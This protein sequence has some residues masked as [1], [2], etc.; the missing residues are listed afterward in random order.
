MEENEAVVGPQR[1]LT[2][3][4]KEVVCEC[5]ES[6]RRIMGAQLMS[7]QKLYR[8]H[9]KTFAHTRTHCRL[10][11]RVRGSNLGHW[12]VAEKMSHKTSM[13]K[14]DKYRLEGIIT[15]AIIN[16]INMYGRFTRCQ[17]LS[18]LTNG[19]VIF[20]I[21]RGFP[22]KQNPKATDGYRYRYKGKIFRIGVGSH[23]LWKTGSPT[24][25]CL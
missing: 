11:K 13:D 21:G 15:A 1:S 10:R 7:T 8:V 20:C 2:G 3:F 25:F 16:I 9:S 18:G 14:M 12:P 24:V 5:M 22:E 23:G 4:L 19:L 17:K 6:E